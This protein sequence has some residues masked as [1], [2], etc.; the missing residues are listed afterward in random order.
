MTVFTTNTAHGASGPHGLIDA[1]KNAFAG[2]AE[3]YRAYLTYTRLE[4]KSDRSLADMGMTRS[5]IARVAASGIL[6]AR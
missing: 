4:A 5:D 2:L 6:N 3:G 1:A